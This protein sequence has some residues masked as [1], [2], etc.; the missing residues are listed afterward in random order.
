MKI[1]SQLMT[2]LVY[3]ACDCFQRSAVQMRQEL[4][5][6]RCFTHPVVN[7][8]ATVAD[9]QQLTYSFCF[10]Y[11][12]YLYSSQIYFDEQFNM[13]LIFVVDQVVFHHKDE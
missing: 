13:E 5:Y 9:N 2:N 7:Q 3:F 10:C 6:R 12:V 11:S 4:E 1:Q 8:T